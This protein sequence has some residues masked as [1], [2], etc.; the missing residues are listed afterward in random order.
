MTP[1]SV[2]NKYWSHENGDVPAWQETRSWGSSLAG[3][4]QLWRHH[5]LGYDA[6]TSSYNTY[7]TPVRGGERNK[8]D[9][10]QEWR[11]EDLRH[12]SPSA[13][14]EILWALCYTGPKT[15][16]S[17]HNGTDNSRYGSIQQ[18]WTGF[19]D[20]CGKTTGNLLMKNQQEGS[21]LL[22]PGEG[23]VLVPWRCLY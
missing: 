11:E 14:P 16:F 6:F 21:G 3:C 15:S 17:N 20:T 23:R 9:Q 1:E 8:S 4:K 7:P 2:R 19:S 12:L 22:V 18:Y 10:Y 5:F 13:E